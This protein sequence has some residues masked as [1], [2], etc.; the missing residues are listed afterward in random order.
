MS[1]PSIPRDDLGHTETLFGLGNGYL[2]MRANPEE[3]RDAHS[4][5]TYV[6]GFHETWEIQHAEE[7]IRVSRRSVRPSS[8]SPTAKLIKLYVDDEPLLLSTADIEEYERSIDFR[9]GVPACAI[10][11]GEPP[12]ARGSESGRHG[13]CRWPS[14]TWP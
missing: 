4:H 7:R 3:G 13:W 1:K 9:T 12:A 8:M 10:S 2:G 5:G 14:D 11:C 6:N